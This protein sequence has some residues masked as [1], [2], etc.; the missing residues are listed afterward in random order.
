MAR[1]ALQVLSAAESEILALVWRAGKATV[2]KICDNLPPDRK[3]AYATVQTLLRRL[4]K[5]GYVAHE[6]E[7]KAHVFFASV[8][9]EEVKSRCL[10]DFVGRLFG[11]DP[12]SLMIHFA[13]HGEIESKDIERLKELIKK[14]NS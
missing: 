9:P 13:E 11:G 14:K 8:K 1:N 2:Q 4:E 6:V 12:M 7:G 3:I 5:K 10:N